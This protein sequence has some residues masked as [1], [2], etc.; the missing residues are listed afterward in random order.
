MA[1]KGLQLN[2]DV[3]FQRKEWLV[4][5]ATWTILGGLLIAAL[6][7]VFGTGAAQPDFRHK[8]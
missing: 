1:T 4:E 6:L 2:D 5:R 3:S 7:G 8:R